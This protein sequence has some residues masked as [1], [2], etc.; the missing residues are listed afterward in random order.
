MLD[1][2]TLKEHCRIE[3][4][5][6]AEDAALTVYAGAAK[7]FVEN[8]TGRELYETAEEIPLDSEGEPEVT[9]LVVDDAIRAAM[10]LLAGHWYANREAVVVGS[11]NSALAYAVDSLIQPYRMYHI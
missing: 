8:A 9:G 3:P 1:L 11:I 6:T 10:L 4:G 7:R 2:P 5:S